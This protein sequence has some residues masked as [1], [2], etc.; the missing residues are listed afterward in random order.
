MRTVPNRDVRSTVERLR[1]TLGDERYEA[2]Y[3]AGA[4]LPRDEATAELRKRLDV[5]DRRTAS[6]FPEPAGSIQAGAGPSGSLRTGRAKAHE[7]GSAK[8]R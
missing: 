1:A 8:A 5:P 2:A 6:G 4:S 7:P 3:D